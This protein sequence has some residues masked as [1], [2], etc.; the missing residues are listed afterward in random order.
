M[1]I[2]SQCLADN[3]N[4]TYVRSLPEALPLW[5]NLTSDATILSYVIGVHIPF[6]HK[7]VQV[8]TPQYLIGRLEMPIAEREIE[9]LLIKGVLEP[10]YYE[11]D[12]FV[13]NFFLRPKKQPGKLRLICNLKELNEFVEYKHLKME[14]VHSATNM[15]RRGCH[16]ATIDLKDAYH[17]VPISVEHRKFWK[18]VWKGKLYRHTALPFGIYCAPYIFLL[19]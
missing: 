19:S 18:I 12:Q 13:S 3:G 11:E 8:N 4:I 14:T 16:M 2:H 5:H 15:M 6:V 1:N 17:S 7:P 9:V 10:S